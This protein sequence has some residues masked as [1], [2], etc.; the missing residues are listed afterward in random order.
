MLPALWSALVDQGDLS[1]E[2]LWDGL[3]FGPS[4]FLDQ[5]AESLRLGSR[6]RLLF[7]LEIS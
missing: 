1:I 2:A 7:D 4:A 5:P 6:R 3:S